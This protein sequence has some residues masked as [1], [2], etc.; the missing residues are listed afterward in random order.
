[1]C[2]TIAPSENLLAA[3]ELMKV[4]DYANPKFHQRFYKILSFVTIP[5]TSRS[6]DE[7]YFDGN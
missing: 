3:C 2:V 5:R 6:G 4:N 7:I 1:V